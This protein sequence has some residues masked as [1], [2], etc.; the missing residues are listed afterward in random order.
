MREPCVNVSLISSLYVSLLQLTERESC[1]KLWT[2]TMVISGTEALFEI[3]V[4]KDVTEELHNAVLET[5]CNIA[6][7]ETMATK[8]LDFGLDNVV[9]LLETKVWLVVAQL[10]SVRPS[11]PRWDPTRNQKL[12]T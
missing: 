5:I 6:N 7:N 8:L 12:I 2:E 10:Y 1:S 9:Q 4:A 11:V 3:L